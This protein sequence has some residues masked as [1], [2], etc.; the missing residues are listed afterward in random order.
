MYK[1]GFALV[2]LL[3]VMGIIAIL[4]SLSIPQLFRLRD[5]N[6][7]HETKTKIISLIRQQQLK[8]MNSPSAYGVA[9]N[10]TSYTL[11]KGS[12]FSEGDAANTNEVLSYPTAFADIEFPSS[13]IVFAS[14]SGEIISFNALQNSVALTD[15]VHNDQLVMQFNSYGVPVSQ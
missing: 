5:R 13:Q 6:T 3:V 7:L 8:A 15:Y 9:F 14:G 10:Q 11:F 4:F 12:Q 1:K 2:E